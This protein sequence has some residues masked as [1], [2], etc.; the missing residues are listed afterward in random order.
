MVPHSNL[1]EIRKGDMWC[2]NSPPVWKIIRSDLGKMP[3]EKHNTVHVVHVRKTKRLTMKLPMVPF[4]FL[5]VGVRHSHDL[6]TMGLNQIGGVVYC[7][8]IKEETRH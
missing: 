2:I 1:N 8:T 3:L 6:E 7:N 5:L 4:L